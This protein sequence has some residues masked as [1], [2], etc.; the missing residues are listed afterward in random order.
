MHIASDDEFVPQDAQNQII[1]NFSNMPLVE[2]MQHDNV[3][4]A[5]A[6]IDGIHYNAHAANIAN[7]KT[8]EF[9]N[10]YL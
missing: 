1:Q 2:T 10:N 4:H 3:Q 7:K 6:R 9:F 8:T 5:F